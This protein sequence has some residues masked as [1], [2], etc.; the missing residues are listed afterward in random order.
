MN[1]ELQQ[2][3]VSRDSS[4]HKG[5]ARKR[6][7]WVCVVF[8]PVSL[9]RRK[10]LRCLGLHTCCHG[11]D[12]NLNSII[13]MEKSHMNEVECDTNTSTV[14]V[15][16]RCVNVTHA[17]CDVNNS[18]CSLTLNVKLC[19][20]L[21][22]KN[23]MWNYEHSCTK[24]HLTWA[25]F[26]TCHCSFRLSQGRLRTQGWRDV[27]HRPLVNWSRSTFPQLPFSVTSISFM[28]RVVQTGG[29]RSWIEMKIRLYMLQDRIDKY[30][31]WGGDGRRGTKQA[32]HP[33]LVDLVIFFF[34]EE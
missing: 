5:V 13:W 16:V 25:K 10:V 29:W 3:R 19:T 21:S 11:N 4:P 17:I 15:N 33:A 20:F 28:K 8:F 23:R 30:D 34:L 6:P 9:S 26:Q 7:W 14:H 24:L 27:S 32:W 18:Q 12:W 1:G 31:T 22:N 2:R